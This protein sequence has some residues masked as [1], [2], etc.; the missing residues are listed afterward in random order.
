MAVLAD[1]EDVVLVVDGDDDHRGVVLDDLADGLDLPVAL[2]KQ[3]GVASQRE[4]LPAVEP[5]AVCDPL[6]HAP[7]ARGSMERS[8]LRGGD[9][10]R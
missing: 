6:S 7:S 2:G 5:L 9:P 8:R 1:E 4:N 3:D 10:S